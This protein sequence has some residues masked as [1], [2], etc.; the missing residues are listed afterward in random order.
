M[1]CAARRT[2]RTAGLLAGSAALFCAPIIGTAAVAGV[3]SAFMVCP[4]QD[5]HHMRSG[6]VLR[7]SDMLP[8]LPPV[9]ILQT[10]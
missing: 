1:A 3:A 4:E 6:L 5:R 7:D 2:C 10:D 9:H 8:R